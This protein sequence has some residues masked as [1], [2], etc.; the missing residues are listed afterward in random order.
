M[1]DIYLDLPAPPDQRIEKL[2]AW[3]ATHTDGSE[4]IVS[5][6]LGPQVM[7]LVTSKRHVA[8]G[9]KSVAERAVQAAAAQAS[10]VV[11]VRLVTFIAVP[12][13]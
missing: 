3:I 13:E 7:P 2:H 4:G 8:E 11:S 12:G 10:K 1:G 9:L 5:A 6:A